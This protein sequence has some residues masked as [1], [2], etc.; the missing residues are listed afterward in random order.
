MVLVT[1]AD[2]FLGF[3]IVKYLS[4]KGIQV[5]A[6]V[7]NKNKQR[8][9]IKNVTYCFGDLLDIS[10]LEEAIKGVDNIIHSAAMVSFQPKDKDALY[11]INV[12]GT[13]NVVNVALHY[14]VKKI[15]FISSVEA[16]DIEQKDHIVTESIKLEI[17][18]IST[19]YGITKHLAEREIWR[20]IAEGLEGV[21]LN[22]GGIIHGSHFNAHPMMMV[23]YTE[24]GLTYHME[25]F[26]PFIDM[27]DFLQITYRALTEEKFNSQQ[28]IAISENVPFGELVNML[29]ESLQVQYKPKILPTYMQQ[30]GLAFEYI[31]S[32]I[33]GKEAR[34]TKEYL[35][36][37][38][39][40]TRF[41]NKKITTDFQL[42]YKPIRL[43]LQEAVTAYKQK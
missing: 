11:K 4:G 35:H 10:S 5:R 13:A 6:L 2:G 1:G 37:A 20:G 7:R 12:E 36:L 38:K 30:L 15:V 27:S 9:E 42:N 26:A 3:Q 18:H 19:T 14:Q 17:K 41:S 23:P 40:K 8:A 32:K 25:G 33:T 16:L 29:I 31:K 39:R 22:P 43:S 34:L 28:Y 21:I 24:Q